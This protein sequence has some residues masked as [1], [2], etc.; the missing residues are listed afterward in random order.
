VKEKSH[1]DLSLIIGNYDVR[2]PS[3]SEG[4]LLLLTTG[5]QLGEKMDQK[6]EFKWFFKWKEFEFDL[7]DATQLKLYDR[8]LLA[9]PA[10]LEFADQFMRDNFRAMLFK[11]RE[12]MMA[13]RFEESMAVNNVLGKGNIARNKRRTNL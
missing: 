7:V 12:E 1:V 5:V 2:F 11:E 13:K 6:V 4:L 9:E 8:R 3:G 10:V